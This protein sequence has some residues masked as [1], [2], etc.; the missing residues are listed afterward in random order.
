MIA[1]VFASLFFIVISPFH[2]FI[3]VNIQKNCT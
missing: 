3:C 2:L 1:V